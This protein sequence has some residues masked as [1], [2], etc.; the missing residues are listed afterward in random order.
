MATTTIKTTSSSLVRNCPST[1]TSCPPTY[2]YLS[3]YTSV[4]V[5]TLYYCGDASTSCASTTT[6]GAPKSAALATRGSPVALVAVLSQSGGPAPTVSSLPAHGEPANG[7]LGSS[8]Q[9]TV[10][11]LTTVSG[12]VITKYAPCPTG[13]NPQPRS[14]GRIDVHP[15]TRTTISL[16]SLT[17]K[18]TLVRA[19]IETGQ[20]GNGVCA[21]RVRKRSI[22]VG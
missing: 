12:S 18:T 17:T 16:A 4:F 10:I 20:S 8:E 3:T 14:N 5:T 15:Y 9:R 22:L 7:G 2:P 19:P 11:A 13:A 21:C 6:Y 1:L